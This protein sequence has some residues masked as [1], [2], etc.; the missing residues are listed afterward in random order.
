MRLFFEQDGR[1]SEGCRRFIYSDGWILCESGTRVCV[2]RMLETS[3][4]CQ[5]SIL[6]VLKVCI[7]RKQTFIEPYSRLLYH[8][9]QMWILQRWVQH[10]INLVFHN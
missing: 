10:G 4:N 9:K 8:S 1:A 2:S 3:E 5:N 6:A 7:L